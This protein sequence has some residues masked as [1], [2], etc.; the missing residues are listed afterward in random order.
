[1]IVTKFEKDGRGS[2]SSKTMAGSNKSS[3]SKSTSTTSGDYTRESGTSGKPLSPTCTV[4]NF[5][6]A[7]LALSTIM[8][9]QNAKKLG[10]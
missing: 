2:K 8:T 3:I 10:F 6:T 5:D 9:F 7:N 1:V 4:N